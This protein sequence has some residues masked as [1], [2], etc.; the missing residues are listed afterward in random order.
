MS[1]DDRISV[2]HPS[3]MPSGI[4]FGL[5]EDRYHAAFALS[6]HGIK[7]LRQS[8]LDF[9]C[10]CPALNPDA[11]RLE[12]KE[13]EHLTIG[14]AYDARIV[15]GCDVFEKRFAARLDKGEYPTAL[16]TNFQI[17][18]AIEAAGGPTKLIKKGKLKAELIAILA[19]HDPMALIWDTL[20]RGH[21]EA[22]A[23]KDLLPRVVMDRIE[24]AAKMIEAHPVLCKAFTGGM[25]QVSVFWEDEIGV[26]CKA[27]F[28]Y[29]KPRAII[30][31]KSYENTRS[32]PIQKAI[33]VAYASYRYNIQAAFYLEAGD[34]LRH[35]IDDGMVSGEVNNGFIAALH[36]APDRSFLFCWQ[37]KGPAPVA[38]G[39]M[40]PPGTLAVGQM[41]IVEAKRAFARCWQT[42]GT[43]PWLDIAD[44]Y[45][46]DDTE[47]PAFIND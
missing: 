5:D 37:Q 17:S 36:D 1:D 47:I 14:R 7:N 18:E 8:T 16:H 44:L 35:L 24:V 19:Q 33:A 40:P 31:L 13:A 34:R 39:W 32:L 42:Y 27:R 46:A 22:H 10:R 43:D 41:Q 2:D 28:D 45:Q 11:A 26:P 38:R 20:E 30:D 23:G 6:S 25:P 21:R 4:Y 12:A 3:R 15:E 29:L 9:W